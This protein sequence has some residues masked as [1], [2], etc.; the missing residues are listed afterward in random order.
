MSFTL[1][2]NR[3]EKFYIIFDRNDQAEKRAFCQKLRKVFPRVTIITDTTDEPFSKPW[4]LRT[5]DRIRQ[6]HRV[7]CLI[8]AQTFLQNSVSWELTLSYMQKKNVVGVRL[9]DD[10]LHM[11]PFLLIDHEAPIIDIAIESLSALKSQNEEV[12]KAA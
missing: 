2:Q 5:Q 9:F 11:T 8:G 1:H 4:M 3:E 12:K 7:F 6:A 10:H